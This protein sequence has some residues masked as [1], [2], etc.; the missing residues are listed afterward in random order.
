M[1]QFIE[2]CGWL[3]SMAFM[4]SAMPQAWKSYKDGHTEGITWLTTSLW[5]FG[6]VVS[7]IYVWPKGYLP[8]IL[9]YGV[10]MIF[11]YVILHY[12]IWPRKNSTNKK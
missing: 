4:V 8:L 11:T 1:D 12:K 2:L 10:Q 7:L 6:E 5:F 3:G 9:N